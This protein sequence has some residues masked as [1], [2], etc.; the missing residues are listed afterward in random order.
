MSSFFV[1]RVA[2]K[3][4]VGGEEKSL[5][6]RTPRSAGGAFIFLLTRRRIIIY[7]WATSQKS[8][9]AALPGAHPVFRLQI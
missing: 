7:L 3:I 2:R 9:G 8:M 5:K 1:N 6:N 4:G